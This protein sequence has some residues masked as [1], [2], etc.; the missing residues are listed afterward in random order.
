[1]EPYKYLSVQT[2]NHIS[3][4]TL[5][6]PEACN[7]VHYDLLA[8]LEH[9]ALGFR[10]DTDTRVVVFT[11]AGRHFCAGADLNELS[12]KKDDSLILRR[13][14]LRIGERVLRAILGIDQITVCAWNGAAAG[15]GGCLAVATD[16]RIGAQDSFIFYPEIDLGVNLMWQSLPRL[17]RLVGESRALR[18]AAGG[19]RVAAETLLNWGLLEEIVPNAELMERTLAFAQTYVKKAPIAVQMIKRSVNAIGSHLDQALMH[20]D[21][22][23]HLLVAQSSD[24]ELAVNA[25][26]EKREA[27][28]TGN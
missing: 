14:R 9:C 16:F 1:M 24:H 25:Y 12:S 2:D 8:E 4:V 13:R 20:M 19:E 23:Q 26:M 18:L 15:G 21:A 3:I 5:N 27:D 17:V 10:E 22:D 6:R 28:F 7:A 11:G